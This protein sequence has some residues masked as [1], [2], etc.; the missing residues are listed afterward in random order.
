[1]V[2]A[3]AKEAELLAKFRAPAEAVAA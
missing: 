1:V 2:T 3:K